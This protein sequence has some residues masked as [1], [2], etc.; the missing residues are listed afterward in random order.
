MVEGKQECKSGSIH[1]IN[2]FGYLDRTGG[3][4]LSVCVCVCGDEKGGWV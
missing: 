4:C 1:A 3:C 2:A